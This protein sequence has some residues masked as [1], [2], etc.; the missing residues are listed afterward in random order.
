M[1]N[2]KADVVIIGAGPA[3][4]LAAALLC[5]AGH[6]VSMFERE[7]FPRF[8][9]GES[10]LPQSMAFLEKAGALSKIEAAGFQIKNGAAFQWGDQHSIIDFNKKFTKGWSQT[11][12]VQRARFDH[13]LADHASEC[14]ADLHF[15]HT[16]QSY[17]EDENGAVLEGVDAQGQPYRAEGRFVLD[18]SGYGRVLPRLLKLEKPSNFPE[19]KAIFTHIKDNISHPL[20]DRK[21]IL[22]TVHHRHQDIWYWLIPFSDGTSSIGVV[23]SV[24]RIE[25]FGSDEEQRL[26][27]LI[28]D[29]THLGIIMPSFEFVR[30]VG[31]MTG[32]S[33]SVTSLYGSKYAL[34]G[35]AGEFLDPVFSS[36]LTIAFKSSDLATSLLCRQLKG[37]KVDWE[38]EYASPL[39]IGVDAFRAFVEGWYDGTLQT[40]IFNQPKEDNEIKRMIISILA[41]Y[42]WDESNPFVKDGKHLLNLVAQRLD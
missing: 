27:A 4:S 16:I 31:S 19:R 12:E 3:G 18:A 32:Y 39:K 42:A 5:R 28:A 21:K 26:K 6:S 36:G 40:V 33:C 24:E 14:G 2:Y 23:G 17:Q 30:V 8:S 25:S 22:I 35:N 7:K 41:G 9:I 1:K 11:F 13:V 29:D 15:N 37:G 10:L 34:L 20:F 38:N